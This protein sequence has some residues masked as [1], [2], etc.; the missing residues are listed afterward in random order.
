MSINLWSVIRV[1]F[2][3]VRYGYRELRKAL[4]TASRPSGTYLVAAASVGEVEAA[5]GRESYAPNWEFSYYE[6]G[7]VLNL[8]RVEYEE[9]TVD[10]TMYRWWQT[11]VRG[12]D[13]PDGVALKAHWELEPTEN[14][15]AHIDGVGFG[16]DRGMEN[17]QAVLDRSELAYTETEIQVE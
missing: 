12:W 8:A 3:A 16:H 1:P 13:H 4:F 6:R 14:G 2:D 15:N 5:L 9:R 10:G 11:H 7:E 17:L